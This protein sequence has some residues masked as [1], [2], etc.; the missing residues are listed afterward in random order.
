MN[1]VRRP[2]TI[3]VVLV[4]LVALAVAALLGATAGAAPKTKKDLVKV[5]VRLDFFHSE[6]HTGF[7]ATKDKGYWE[8]LGL[9]VVINPGAGSG[10][11]VQQ[12]A[13][14]NDMIGWA[15]AVAMTQQVSKGAD[16]IAIGSMRQLFD[17]GIAYWPDSGISKATDLHG[18]TCAFTASGFIALLFPVWAP[19]AGV[20]PTKINLRVTDAAAGSAL[21]GAHQVDCLES[22]V[23]QAKNFYAPRNGVSPDIIRYSDVGMNPLGFVLIMNSRQARGNPG[24]ATKFLRGLIQGWV[25]GC[26]NPRQAVTLARTHFAAPAYDFDTGVNIWKT[27]CGLQRTANSKGMKLGATALADWNQTVAL[28]RGAPSLGVQTN[29]PPPATLFTNVWIDNA[30]KGLKPIKGS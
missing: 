27:V 6:A 18:K 4:A 10:S 30:W 24:I 2:R 21:F 29:V 9:D 28:V 16:V 1:P 14:G 20:D 25:W 3:G 5:S 19:K 17:G 23:V 8:K 12:I 13:A 7:L 26:A 15:N 11:T 22:T